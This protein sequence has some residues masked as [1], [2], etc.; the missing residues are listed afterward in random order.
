[1]FSTLQQPGGLDPSPDNLAEDPDNDDDSFD[2]NQH[3][4]Y[5]TDW[6][7][8]QSHQKML[9]STVGKNKGLAEGGEYSA[10]NSRGKATRKKLRSG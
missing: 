6:A 10:M 3:D 7:V 9:S 1:M 8:P 4:E 5:N 2:D